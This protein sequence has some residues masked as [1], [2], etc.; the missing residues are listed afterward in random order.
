[1][2]E[3]S[4]IEWCDHTFNPWIGCSAALFWLFDGEGK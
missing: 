2:A 3:F 4:N 1:M